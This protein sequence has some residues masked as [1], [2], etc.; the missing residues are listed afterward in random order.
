MGV[1]LR[2]L[3]ALCCTLVACGCAS[4]QLGNPFSA[5]A[6]S[7][8]KKSTDDELLARRNSTDRERGAT[9]T[10]SRP[11]PQDDFPDESGGTTPSRFASRSGT[12]KT[13]EYDAKTQALIESE[14]R[15]ASPEER[16]ALLAELKG[17]HPDSVQ[18]VL[19]VRRMGLRYQEQQLSVASRE[20]ADRPR[21]DWAGLPSEA[22]NVTAGHSRTVQH[23]Y[24]GLGSASAWD[25]PEKENPSSRQAGR[26][27]FDRTPETNAEW[28]DDGTGG[29]ARIRPLSGAEESGGVVT[30]DHYDNGDPRER[31]VQYAENRPGAGTGHSSGYR[32]NSQGAN[33]AAELSAQNPPARKLLGDLLPGRYPNNGAPANSAAGSTGAQISPGQ[34]ALV[35]AGAPRSVSPGGNSVQQVSGDTP[36]TEQLQRLIATAEVEA[37]RAQPGT[38]DAE[39][40]EYLRKQVHLRMLYLISGQHERALQAIPGIE[41]ADQEFWQ[42]TFWG[43][44]NYFDEKTI[45]VAADRATQTITQMTN[46]VLRLQ[47]KA[48]LD[49]RNVTLCH[50]ISSFGNYEKYPRDEFTPGQEV[51]LY[52]EVGNIH[53]EPTADGK[54]R[55]ILKST[56]EIYRPGKQGE[57]VE[58]IELPAPATED[59]CRAHRRDYFHSYQFTIP[60]KV[61][62]GPHVL[63]LTVEDQISRR[64]ATSTVNFTVK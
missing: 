64:V 23:N 5:S 26:A 24:S 11:H 53:S 38:T 47:E 1:P 12:G 46:A 48:S 60:S 6:R 49:L 25:R 32:P 51:L 31:Y 28:R 22:G 40:H 50:K 7:A 43:L 13:G 62:L 21:N 29:A 3:V 44:A 55:T 30:A 10:A 57:L 36:A 56:L 63:K 37:S 2:S 35:Q 52:A 61:A 45:P 18:Q 54:Y 58:R 8:T 20:R 19:R 34:G 4:S 41:A 39:K 17:L 59:I 15:D 14:L 16:A 9:R 33:A 27:G 42:Q